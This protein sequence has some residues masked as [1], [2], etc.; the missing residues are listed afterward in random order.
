M[1]TQKIG[2]FSVQ[3]EL[4][5]VWNPSTIKRMNFKENSLFPTYPR[6]LVLQGV[7]SLCN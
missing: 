3:N 6:L 1:F 2:T 5:K 7:F 4:S